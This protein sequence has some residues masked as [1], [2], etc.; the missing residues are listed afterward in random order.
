[1]NDWFNVVSHSDDTDA[2]KS[3]SWKRACKDRFSKDFSRAKASPDFSLGKT[4]KRKMM[5]GANLVV[6]VFGASLQTNSHCL[7]EISGN[8]TSHT[9][10]PSEGKTRS[11]DKI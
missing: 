11:V 2:P 9:K 7:S 4:H 1:M 5:E 3:G 8:Q 10:N 6:L